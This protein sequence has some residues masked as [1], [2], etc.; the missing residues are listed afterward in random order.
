[1][2][3]ALKAAVSK[4]VG[5]EARPVLMGWTVV[6]AVRACHPNDE[7]ARVKAVDPLDLVSVEAGYQCPSVSA[8]LGDQR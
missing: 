1:M 5:V 2:N 6:I 7:L 3:K 8:R 4:N